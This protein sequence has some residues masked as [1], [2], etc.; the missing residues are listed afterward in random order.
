[1][2]LL[3]KSLKLMLLGLPK[4]FEIVNMTFFTKIQ[5]LLYSKIY[6]A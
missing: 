1:M 4:M 5:L 3:F 2:M 6:P